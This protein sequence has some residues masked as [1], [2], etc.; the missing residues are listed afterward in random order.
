MG[1]KGEYAL[2]RLFTDNPLNER[3]VVRADL[4]HGSFKNSIF[5]VSQ[6][7]VVWSLEGRSLCTMPCS[8][9]GGRT[10]RPNLASWAVNEQ[11]LPLG[12]ARPPSQQGEW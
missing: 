11:V 10:R 5:Q 1:V 4:F 8:D 2:W 9:V 12:A 6:V 3:V 7:F